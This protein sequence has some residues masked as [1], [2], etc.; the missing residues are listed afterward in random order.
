MLAGSRPSPRWLAPSCLAPFCGCASRHFAATISADRQPSW[1]FSQGEYAC[2]GGSVDQIDYLLSVRPAKRAP[3]PAE[4]FDPPRK[5]TENVS[6]H[7]LPS[8]TCQGPLDT[9]LP[10][11]QLDSSPI[12][13]STMPESM[14]LDNRAK[15]PLQEAGGGG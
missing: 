2:L 12:L 13:E 8:A 4:V 9:F 7:D 5:R 1:E 3:G 14:D 10:Q 11:T 6:V 15:R